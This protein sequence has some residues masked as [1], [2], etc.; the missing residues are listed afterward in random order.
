MEDFDLFFHNWK[1]I[2]ENLKKC[3][4][5]IIKSDFELDSFI[6]IFY[7]EGLQP[8]INPIFNIEEKQLETGILIKTME[9]LL[10][11]K[12]ISIENPSDTKWI[13]GDFVKINLPDIKDGNYP[14]GVLITDEFIDEHGELC[15]IFQPIEADKPIV[16]MKFKLPTKLL[17]K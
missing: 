12:A 4:I 15:V 10:I 1:Q 13:K 17:F 2:D 16:G 7:K 11:E 6:Q 3:S 9:Q 8:I 5:K 14:R